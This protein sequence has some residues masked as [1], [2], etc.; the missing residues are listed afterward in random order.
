MRNFKVELKVK[1]WE[2]QLNFKAVMKAKRQFKIIW[3]KTNFSQCEKNLK[4][5]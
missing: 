5:N 1:Y 4:Q 3:P 2:I